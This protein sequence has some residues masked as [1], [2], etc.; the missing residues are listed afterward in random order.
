MLEPF[1]GDIT[2]EKANLNS[3]WFYLPVR[4][5]IYGEDDGD[6]RIRPQLIPSKSRISGYGKLEFKLYNLS[7][8]TEEVSRNR[9][10]HYDATPSTDVSWGTR[11]VGITCTGGE[12][13]QIHKTLRYRLAVMNRSIFTAEQTRP[14][15]PVVPLPM[16]RHQILRSRLW[17]HLMVFVISTVRQEP[18]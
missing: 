16:V 13:Y 9:E 4:N 5:I 10:D 7:N 3:D 11:S 15:W 17:I 18:G 1:V 8:L 6:D 2:I 12:K 14:P